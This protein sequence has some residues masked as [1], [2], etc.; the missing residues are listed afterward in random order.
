MNVTQLKISAIKLEI[1]RQLLD[2]I[3][4][5]IKGLPIGTLQEMLCKL[6]AASNAVQNDALQNAALKNDEKKSA[7]KKRGGGRGVGV[8]SIEVVG[9]VDVNMPK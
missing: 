9:V 3:N 5:E 1:E 4:E 8:A 6:S 2:S 7:I